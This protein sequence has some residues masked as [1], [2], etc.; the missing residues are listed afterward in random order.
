[1]TL[2]ESQ[3]DEF[4]GTPMPHEGFTIE[5][6]AQ[7]HRISVNRQSPSSWVQEFPGQDSKGTL[8]RPEEGADEKREK[9]VPRV[10]SFSRQNNRAWAANNR[11]RL[12]RQE[13]AAPLSLTSFPFSVIV[14]IGRAW[15]SRNSA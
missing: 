2:R 9:G 1:M 15:C 12:R 11:L 13:R 3:F 6:L 8:L 14:R 10:T 5:E 7:G 4:F